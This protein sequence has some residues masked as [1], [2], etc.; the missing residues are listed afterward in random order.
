MVRQIVQIERLN[1]PWTLLAINVALSG[2][3]SRTLVKSSL[4]CPGVFKPREQATNNIKSRSGATSVEQ[5]WRQMSQAIG[6]TFSPPSGHHL[7]SWTCGGRT[8]SFAQSK[9]P[10]VP[11]LTPMQSP[12][13]RPCIVESMFDDEG[14]CR[15]CARDCEITRG[16]QP[17]RRGN[18]R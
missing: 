12:N 8:L 16:V 7:F 15:E 6:M 9:V 11:R 13:L 2:A 4:V 14:H 10:R 3:L 18:L 1:T 5:C 17:N